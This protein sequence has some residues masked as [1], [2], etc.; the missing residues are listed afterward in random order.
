MKKN[1]LFALLCCCMCAFAVSCSDDDDDVISGNDDQTENEGGSTSDAAPTVLVTTNAGSDS[2]TVG[3]T[4]SNTAY[5]YGYV[6]STSSLSV[7]AEQILAG[8]FSGVTSSGVYTASSDGTYKSVVIDADEST[9]YYVYAAAVSEGGTYSTVSSTTVTTLAAAT[10]MAV[11]LNYGFGYYYGTYYTSGSTVEY[12]IYLSETDLMSTGWVEGENYYILSFRSTT[13]PDSDTVVLPAGTYT[14]SSTDANNTLYMEDSLYGLCSGYSDDEGVSFD[15]LLGFTSGSLTVSVSSGITT[16]EGTLT[17]E[18]G[19][20]HTVSYSGDLYIMDAT[21][22]YSY[23][24]LTE[25]VTVDL[26]DAT[27]YAYYEGDAMETSTSFW[28]FQIYS[29]DQ[30]QCFQVSYC[31]ST[32]FTAETG[33]ATGTYTGEYTAYEGTYITGIVYSGYLYYSWYISLSDGAMAEPYSPFGTGEVT[34]TN[35]GDG[36][37]TI[38]IDVMDDAETYSI[39]GTWTGTPTIYDYSSY[40]SSSS[41]KSANNEPASRIANRFEIPLVNPAFGKVDLR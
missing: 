40:Y 27:C 14:I 39:K 20:I 41:V 37:Y 16:I 25:D 12:Y 26:T 10:T 13:E 11:D 32:D 38:D 24:T 17:D 30:T 35:N 4:V 1:W 21:A 15:P 22:S 34:V 23:S 9:T 8:S 28:E 7:T 2:F 5:Q 33:L 18:E 36:T 3:I 29:A 31:G 6:A 19:T